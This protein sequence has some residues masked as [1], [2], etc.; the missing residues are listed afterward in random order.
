MKARRSAVVV[1]LVAVASLCLVSTTLAQDSG[2]PL[3]GSQLDQQLEAALS[4][5]GFTGRVEATLETRL[6]RRVDHQ[7]ADLGRLLWFDTFSD[8]SRMGSPT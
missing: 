1:M 6:G 5:A 8:I 3:R 7:L 2:Q 4:A